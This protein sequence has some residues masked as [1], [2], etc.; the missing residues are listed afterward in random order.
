V[1]LRITVLKPLPGVALG[2]QKGKAECA[3]P[4]RRNSGAVAFDF[5]ARIRWINAGD[6]LQ[7]SGEFVQGSAGDRF[8]YV[9]VNV[10]VNSILPGTA[11]RR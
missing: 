8:V 4:S 11:A 10:P 2:L 3:P 9:T 5:S 6:A 7:W 1:P